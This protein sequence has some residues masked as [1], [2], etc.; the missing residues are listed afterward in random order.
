M[1]ITLPKDIIKITRASKKDR[2]KAFRFNAS[3]NR[4]IV[5]HDVVDMFKGLG[6]DMFVSPKERCL[7][8]SFGSSGQTQFSVNPKNGYVGCKKLFEWARNAEAP[9]FE[10]YLYEDYQIDRK[11]KIVRVNLERE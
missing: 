1:I 7:Y 6:I 5:P 10:D 4:A 9:M 3:R 8:L 11:N 2:I